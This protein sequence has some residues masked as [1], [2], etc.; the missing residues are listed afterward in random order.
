MS[1]KQIAFLV[2]DKEPN[3]NNT[4]KLTCVK[5]DD[6]VYANDLD[7]SETGYLLISPGN[8]L[9]TETQQRVLI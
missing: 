4:T 2:T 5:Y 6:K 9:I 7:F 1:N 3:D 8:Y